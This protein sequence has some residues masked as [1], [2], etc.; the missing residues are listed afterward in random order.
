MR[1]ALYVVLAATLACAAPAKDA[2]APDPA[3][4]RKAIEASNTAQLAAIMKGDVQGAV[5]PYADDA[6]VFNPGAP[7]SKGKAATSGMFEGMFKAMAISD[8]A[9][10]TED[11]IVSGDLAVEHGTFKWT[12]TPKGAKAMVDS[13]KYVVVWR[14]QAD[15]GW[16]IIR[17]IL[18]SDIAPKM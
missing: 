15:G 10:R 6:I 3:A 9:L 1:P 13:G 12:L 8:A 18:N 5:A 11:V 4:A 17:D 7:M 14:K 16:K 2:P